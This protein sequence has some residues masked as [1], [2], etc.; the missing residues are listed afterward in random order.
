V[1]IGQIWRNTPP[2]SPAIVG[3]L[4]ALCGGAVASEEPVAEVVQNSADTISS[5]NLSNL[6]VRSNLVDSPQ[7]VQNPTPPTAPLSVKGERFFKDRQLIELDIPVETVTDPTAGV[8][9]QVE[10]YSDDPMG[11][12]TNVS[13]LRDV[14]PDDWA[15]EALRSLVER[16]GVIEGYPDGTFRGNRAITRYEFAAGLARA[17]NQIQSLIQTSDAV[18]LEDVAL[19]EKLRQEFILEL[20]LRRADV[21]ALTARTGELELTQ[22][23]STTKLQGEAV[24]GLAGI[25]AGEDANGNDVDDVAV[26][27]H[28]TRLNL[29]TSF[30]GQDLL[31]T[32]LQAEGLN[33]L[34]NRT[35]TREGELAFTGEGES[36]LELDALVYSLPVSDNTTVVFAAQADA[37]Y[38]FAST[39]NPYLDG[40]GA[41]GALSRFGTRPPIYYLLEGTGA[42]IRHEFSERLELSLGYLAGNGSD[43][44]AGLFGGDYGALAQVVF[45]PSE[46]SLIG[47]TYVHA[48]NKDLQTGS[49]NAN[50]FT[51]LGLPTSSNSYGIEASY[52]ISPRFV[53]GGWAGYT[54]ARVIDQ[55]DANIWNWAVTLAFPDLGKPGNLAGIVVGM[56]PKVT[57]SGDRLVNLGISDPSTSLHL[58]AFY[59]YQL[60][61]NLTLTPGV[62]WLT[63]PN[64]NSNNA[65]IVIGT[66]RTTLSF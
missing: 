46:R 16:Y 8:L 39:V 59:Q 58:E 17:L 41:K 48:Y 18:T 34:S 24:L 65:D 26:F 56:E 28:R 12:V 35:Q 30:T 37:P 25:V 1:K 29:N 14:Q 27:G 44:Q 7:Y 21:D 60:A 38:Y 42:G 3:A 64:H 20:S 31:L 40:D 53:L 55:G 22:F 66:L 15:Y 6:T 43:P 54:A 50:L 11:Q 62:I 4:L 2:I 51:Q 32:R 57:N 61:D 45:Q 10:Q 13:Q 52:Q 33:N 9:E 19:L 36:D 63:A 49:N 47:L 5:T 23:S